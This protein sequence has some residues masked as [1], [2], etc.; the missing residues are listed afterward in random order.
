MEKI[1]LKHLAPYLPYGIEVV[2]NERYENETAMLTSINYGLDQDIVLIQ[3]DTEEFDFFEDKLIKIKPILRP[4]SDLTKEIEHDGKKFIPLEVCCMDYTTEIDF[5]EDD[6]AKWQSHEHTHL[7]DYTYQIK[8]FS[9]SDGQITLIE[10]FSK[11]DVFKTQL[12][13][14][15]RFFQLCE[16]HFDVFGLITKGLAIDI[17]TIK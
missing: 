6:V 4:L 15:D 3:S 11:D 1:E 14:Y 10:E 12:L 8:P 17:N 13:N 2:S 16:W 5:I 7:A 9:S